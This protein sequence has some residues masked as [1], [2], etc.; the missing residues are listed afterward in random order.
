VSL[1]REQEVE[2]FM[3]SVRSSFYA[4]RLA[5]GVAT[6]GDMTNVFFATKPSSGAAMLRLPLGT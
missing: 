3:A 1:V 6:E 5:S 4:T 2:G